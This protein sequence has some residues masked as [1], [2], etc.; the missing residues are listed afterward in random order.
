MFQSRAGHGHRHLLT[1]ST[2]LVLGAAVQGIGGMV[3]SLI[4][5][6]IDSKAHFG[7]ATALFTSTLFVTYLSGLGL[8][9]ALARY[10]ADDSHD[11]HAVFAWGALAT[12]VASVAMSG[13]YLGLVHPKAA[14][15]LWDWNPVGG[16]AVFAL[17]VTGSA[18]SLIV[19]VR[20]MTMRRWGLVLARIV[21]VGVVKIALI[22]VGQDSSHRSLLLFVA[23][24]APVAASGFVGLALLPRI[25]GGAHRLRPRPVSARAARR[26]AG[27]NYLSTLAYQA[28]YFALPVIVLV[29]VDSTVNSSFYVAW[30]IV[31]IAFYVPSA[32][33]QALLAEGGKDGAHLH[34]QLRLALGL[35]V[36]LMGVGSVVAFVGK[37]VVVAAYGEAYRDAAHILPAMMLAGIPWALTS[38]LLT[39]ARVRH[40]HVATVVITAT[41]TIAIVVPA[42]VLVPGTGSDHGIDGASLSWLVGNVIAAVVAV[43]VTAVS[44]R[45]EPVTGPAPEPTLGELDPAL[46]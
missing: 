22:G 28:P 38:L 41:L 36:A 24:G 1:G 8:P 19:D 20:A 18:F 6:Q 31:S 10:A 34:S 42:L 14:H 23:L 40:R 2:V 17:I 32:I 13:A 25:T 29:N 12:T 11:S 15:V 7:D 43:V 33:G 46:P 39:E 30:G 26:Y 5:A 4:V 16:F 9:V 44:R 35:A 3:F 21:I 27:I 37:S 45:L